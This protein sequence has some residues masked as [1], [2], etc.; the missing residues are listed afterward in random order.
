MD[1]LL[2]DFNLIKADRQAAKCTDRPVSEH[3]PRTGGNETIIDETGSEIPM[4][5]ELINAKQPINR[6]ENLADRVEHLRENPSD[7]LQSI[8][9]LRLP[10]S[11]QVEIMRK[12][13][14]MDVTNLDAILMALSTYGLPV[15]N[16]L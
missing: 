13:A 15:D 10:M 4:M 2:I 8:M 1:F 12:V 6:A 11:V 5:Q 14:E 7:E 3:D 9:E 16:Y